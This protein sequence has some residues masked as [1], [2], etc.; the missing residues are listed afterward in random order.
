MEPD[1]ARLVVLASLPAS[2]GVFGV[3]EVVRPEPCRRVLDTDLE[4]MVER[5]VDLGRCCPIMFM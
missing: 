2:R 5:G 3:E 1:L 4:W